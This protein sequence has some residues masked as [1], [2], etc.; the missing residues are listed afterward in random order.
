MAVALC[1]AVIDADRLVVDVA[2]CE[3]VSEG[4]DVMDAVADLLIVLVGD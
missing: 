3:A 4:D 2:V 1:V